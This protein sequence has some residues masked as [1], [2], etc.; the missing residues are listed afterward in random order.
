VNETGGKVAIVTGGGSGIGRCTAIALAA[1]GMRVVIGNRRES[2]GVETVR[3]IRANGGEAIF[4]KTDVTKAREVEKLVEAA[5]RGYGRVD[6]AFNNAGIGTA[7]LVA[8][9]KEE[10]FDAVMAVN[11]KGLWLSMKYQLRQMLAQGHGSIV[12]N[13]SVH[14]FR[15]IFPGVSAYTASKHA[16]VALTRAAAVEYAA[17]GIRVNGV[18]PGPIDTEML[19]A[20]ADA[21]GGVDTWRSMIPAKRIGSPEEVANVAAWLMSDS[22]S[23]VTG[24]IVGVDGGFLA[25]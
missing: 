1:A 20:S 8:D 21:I 18:A 19:R 23:F 6:H 7:G 13:V 10:D 16:A 12:N 11:V 24:Q 14:G 9:Q 25:G 3:F 17:S 5:V 2:R 15:T 4:R 22:A